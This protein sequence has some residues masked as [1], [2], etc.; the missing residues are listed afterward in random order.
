MFSW[1][2]SQERVGGG[3]RMSE[4]TGSEVTKDA[5]ACSANAAALDG[6]LGP[7]Y[8]FAPE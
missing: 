7:Y 5:A 8:K 1:S 2:Y 3:M 4:L 6:Y